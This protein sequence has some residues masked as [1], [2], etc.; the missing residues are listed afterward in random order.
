MSLALLLRQRRRLLMQFDPTQ[1]TFSS[2]STHNPYKRSLAHQASAIAHQPQP[3]SSKFPRIDN[4]QASSSFSFSRQTNSATDTATIV[5]PPFA[6]MP[7]STHNQPPRSHKAF[8][9]RPAHPAG[10]SRLSGKGRGGK[11]VS[12]KMLEGPIHDEAF[13]V[14]EYKKSPVPLKPVHEA[15]PKSSLGNFAMLAVGKVPVYKISDG[16][17]ASEPRTLPTQMWR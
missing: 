8:G 5:P 10:P 11:G 16:L 4:P 3:S 2:T 15:T 6:K 14:R 13:I 17:V 7:Q 9:H 1:N 12:R